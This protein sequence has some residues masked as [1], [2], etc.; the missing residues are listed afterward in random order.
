MVD[1]VG[2]LIMTILK[3]LCTIFARS[4]LNYCSSVSGINM[5]CKVDVLL[6]QA[7]CIS[8]RL[9]SLILIGKLC[10]FNWIVVICECRFS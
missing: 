6:L 10:G 2:N 5:D 1:V 8:S 3:K 9:S 4:N 7:D